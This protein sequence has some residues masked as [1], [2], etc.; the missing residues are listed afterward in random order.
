MNEDRDLSLI[1]GLRGS[2]ES[3]CVEF[4]ENLSNPQD[5]GK[6]ISA[7][8][9]AAALAKETYGYLIWGVRDGDH[10]VVGTKFDPARPVHRQPL[11]MWLAQ[12]VRPGSAFDFRTVEHSRGR[13]VLLEIPAA[14]S[15]PITFDRIAYIRINSA[16]PRLAD[17]PDRERALWKILQSTSWEE[18]I[19]MQSIVADKVLALLDHAS[20]FDLT[21]QPFPDNRAGILDGLSQDA[22]IVADIG[23]RWNITN[24]G[25]ILFAKSLRDFGAEIARKAV[26]F[27]SY[28]GSGRYDRVTN[29]KEGVH[30]YATGLSN[31]VAYINDLLP[32]NEHIGQTFRTEERMYPE[33]AI[34]ELV[35]NALIHQDMTITGAGPTVELF[36]DRIEITNPGKPLIDPNRF[37]DASPRS[38]NG[39]ISTLMRRM[40]ICEE[41]GTGIDKAVTE[42]ELFQSPPPDFRV[43]SEATR[44][45]LFA[46]RKFADMTREERIRACYQ[47]AVLRYVSRTRM[48]NNTLRER[49]GLG[50]QNTSK[51]SHVIRAALNAGLIR[52]AD[53]AQPKSG[54]VPIWA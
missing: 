27:A 9:N 46:P 35:A 12:R 4:K 51:V 30:G 34:R 10:A 47:H 8:A 26:R 41:M 40:G 6:Y 28:D 20:Y 23:D 24:L 36:R 32:T 2:P 7:I 54:Y 49:F 44:V 38:Y 39:R 17:H 29:R 5:I 52:L 43:E 15:N 33:V 42:I 48:K 16:T 37:I 22:I 3:E 11:A 53:S 50:I 21:N 18:G 1:E 14:T 25:A 13:L 19:A 45:V 31:F